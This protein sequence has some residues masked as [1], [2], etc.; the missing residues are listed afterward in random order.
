MVIAPPCPVRFLD[1]YMFSAQMQSSMDTA[2]SRYGACSPVLAPGTQRMQSLSDFIPILVLYLLA[3]QS[4]HSTVPGESLYFPAP[5]DEQVRHW[6]SVHSMPS[7]QTWHSCLGAWISLSNTSPMESAGHTLYPVGQMFSF[8]IGDW[9]VHSD[10]TVT[11]NVTCEP[12]HSR[13]GGQ[14]WQSSV[15]GLR[16]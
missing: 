16:M 10:P 1:M 8:M 3:A 15:L 13:P 5:H 11:G 7:G 4:R 14:R 6:S 2:P 12:L 9:M